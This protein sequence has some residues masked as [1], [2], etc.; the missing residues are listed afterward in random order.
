M[1][2]LD[3]K[4]Q[5][6]IIEIEEGEDAEV[7][8]PQP[9][10]VNLGALPGY[11]PRRRIFPR[12]TAKGFVTFYDLGQVKNTSGD[13]IDLPYRR[14]PAYSGTPFSATDWANLRDLILSVPIGDFETHYRKLEYAEAERYGLDIVYEYYSD[15]PVRYPVARNGSR[16]I[17][18]TSE[19]VHSTKWT[20]QGL[21]LPSEHRANI[22][23]LNFGAFLVWHDN[24]NNTFPQFKFTN[25]PSYA[26]PAVPFTLAKDA[27]VFLVPKM[28]NVY[29]LSTDGLGNGD[30]LIAPYRA[31]TR[32]FWLP[33]NYQEIAYPMFSWGGFEQELNPS[34]TDKLA[35]LEDIR[36]DAIEFDGHGVH[37][38]PS[39][40]PRYHT[41]VD[42]S[43]GLADAV[44][45]QARWKEGTLMAVVKQETKAFYIWNTVDNSNIAYARHYDLTGLT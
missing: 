8:A 27:K 41:F 29:A 19:P 14:L 28:E 4:T 3:P 6:V 34:D 39:S 35:L 5:K 36:L 11:V 38:P 15:N 7:K 22:L 17:G 1:I 9:N 26:A 20:P 24:T 40:F 2:T 37:F 32:S 23:F 31:D 21:D 18:E 16:W 33:R 13:W 42:L 43:I 45:P 30:W 10:P 44:N 25:N 12:K